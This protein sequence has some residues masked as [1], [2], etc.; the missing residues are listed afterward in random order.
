MIDLA[1]I[2]SGPAA[3]SAAIYA[4][5][6]NLRVVVF[7]KAK[8]GG[9]LTEIA[10]IRNFPGYSG[11]GAELAKKMEEQC[12]GFGVKI[13]YGEAEKIEKQSDGSFIVMIDGEPV[14]A[15]A[16]IVATGS[17]P[18]KLDISGIE[19]PVSYCAICDGA[20][21]K[22]KHVAVIGGGNSAIQE[23][24]H[25]A[26]IAKDVKIFVRSKITAQ[27]NIVDHLAWEPV[28]IKEDAVLS[29]EELNKFDAIFVYIGK[30][31]ATDFLDASILS[32]D[33][34]IMTENY[35]TKIPGLFAAGDV[36]EGSIKQAITASADGA[37]AA[38]AAVDFL[39]KK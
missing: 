10:K 30:K 27:P 18:K 29:A 7:E 35:E 11:S 9:A 15:R 20:L 22:D 33:G 39:S 5:R 2:G 3:L 37:A 23:S 17:E 4:A 13:E 16:V 31:P 12:K 14:S 1:I 21:Y 8:I 28:V 34:Y 6:S 24:I 36:R 38:L 19:K 26:H 32:D 25:L